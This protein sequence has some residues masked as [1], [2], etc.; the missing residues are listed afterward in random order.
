MNTIEKRLETQSWVQE[1]EKA[2]ST[3]GRWP[4]SKK[5]RN[6]PKVKII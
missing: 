2:D 3:K 4:F 6:R 5:R 1:R